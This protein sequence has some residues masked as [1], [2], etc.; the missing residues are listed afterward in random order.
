MTFQTI[1]LHALAT[2]GRVAGIYVALLVMLRMSGRRELAQLTPID[3]L[4]MLLL[5]ETVSPALTGNDS[6][7]LNG[8]LAA[9]TLI[10]ASLLLGRISYHKGMDL[11]VEGRALL[12]IVRGRVLAEVMRAHRVTDQQLSTALH[13]H[14]L[15]AVEEVEKAFIEPNGQITV[16]PRDRS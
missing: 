6:S 9:G 15:M 3:L 12:L 7:I 2:V 16:V 4:T 10:G 14:G 8:L 1:A 13:E 5:S 11:A